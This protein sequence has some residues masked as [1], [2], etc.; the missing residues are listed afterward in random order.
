MNALPGEF[1]PPT[2]LLLGPGPSEVHPRV[3]RAMSAPLLGHLDPAFIAMMED[4]KTMLR[5]VFA[6]EN[7]SVRTVVAPAASVNGVRDA[8]E[9]AEK[10][11]SASPVMVE[12]PL[13]DRVTSTRI[14]ESAGPPS[15]EATGTI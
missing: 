7:A 1:A 12:A 4:V 10:R 15:C 8:N 14:F 5:A 11:Y 2:R 13:F 9:P 6:T 3:L